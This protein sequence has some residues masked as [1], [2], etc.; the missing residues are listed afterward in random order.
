MAQHACVQTP[1]LRCH[2]C[3]ATNNTL[4]SFTIFFQSPRP[5]HMHARTHVF[6][7]TSPHLI[8]KSRTYV[9]KHKTTQP[10]VVQCKQREHRA[11]PCALLH[12]M[13]PAPHA[14]IKG[15]LYNYYTNSYVVVVAP[16]TCRVSREASSKRLCSR[17][18]RSTPPSTHRP[19]VPPAHSA[20]QRGA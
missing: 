7:R 19:L 20:G 15:I 10:R 12:G 8:R 9:E 13:L 6:T 18:R 5:V 11:A 2:A 4:S 14:R 16:S 3:V 17:A 1:S